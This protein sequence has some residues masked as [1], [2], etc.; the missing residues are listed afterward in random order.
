MTSSSSPARSPVCLSSSLVR[1]QRWCLLNGMCCVCCLQTLCCQVQ[2]RGDLD[3]AWSDARDRCAARRVL[4]LCS[5]ASPRLAVSLLSCVLRGA[6]AA[7]RAAWRAC[8]RP[9]PGTRFRKVRQND[10]TL[11]L[12]LIGADCYLPADAMGRA[13]VK[14][15]A[16]PPI[17]FGKQARRTSRPIALQ[18]S[19]YSVRG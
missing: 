7:S 14:V 17:G 15:T 18:T 8:F 10:M 4:L 11:L 9:C 3:G 19:E 6:C 5:L 16:E 12:R 1:G 13:D 2:V